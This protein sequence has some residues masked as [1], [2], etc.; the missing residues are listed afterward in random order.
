MK[1]KTPT[2]IRF[3]IEK[4]DLIKKNEKLESNQKVVDFLLDE[5]WKLFAPKEKLESKFK[6][7]EVASAKVIKE[8]K[9]RVGQFEINVDDKIS[10][11]AESKR[12]TPEQRK[13][14][15]KLAEGYISN[16]PGK[17]KTPTLEERIAAM[18]AAEKRIS[19]S[20]NK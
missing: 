19:N 6:V 7:I 16:P 18:D 8:G 3:D 1:T 10:A 15:E 5:Y 9:E 12:S 13:N 4:L 20:L 14:F 2:A 17:L 11:L